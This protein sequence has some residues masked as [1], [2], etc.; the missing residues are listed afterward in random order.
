GRDAEW[1]SKSPNWV[2]INGLDGKDGKDGVI[3]GKGIPGA[4]GETGYPGDNVA[5][6]IDNETGTVY[7]RDPNNNDK[8]IPLSGKNGI[9]GIKGIDGAPGTAGTITTL[10][11]IVKDANGNIYAYVGESDTVAGRDAEWA[12]KSPNWVKINGLNGEDGITGAT[13]EPGTA[14]SITTLDAIIKSPNGDIYVYTGTD[15]TVAGRDAEWVA[16]SPNWVKINGNDGVS[17]LAGGPGAPGAP[18]VTIPADATTWIDTETGIVYVKD[19]DGKWV[20]VNGKD[21]VDGA[22]GFAGGPGVPGDP[23]VTIPASTT[24]WI[25]TTT[26]N[27]YVLDPITKEWV[28]VSGANGKDGKSFTYADFTADELAGLKGADGVTSFV[29]TVT[30]GNTIATFTDAAG[31]PAAIKETIT[32]LKD[33]VTETTDVRGQVFEK[34]TLTYTDEAGVESP[35]DMSTLVKGVETL[36]SLEY[37]GSL[38]ELNY[39]DEAGV[40]T[41]FNMVD[42][43][44]ANQ[45]LT[46]L[47]INSDEGTLDYTDE[48]KALH[49]LNLADLVKEPW[50]GVDSKKGATLNTDNIYTQGWVGIG[51]TAPSDAPNEKLRVNGA[52]TTVNSYYA[53]YVFEDYF[54]GFSD[55]K[56][57][58]K[59]KT[60]A[61]ID[62]YIKKNN[63]LPGITPINELMKTKEGYSFNVSEL[64]I[65]LLE[66]TEELYLHIIEQDKELEAKN[67]E[68]EK[69]KV[70]SKS[71]KAA[72]DEMNA[73]LEKL[74]K[75]MSNK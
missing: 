51:F 71:L 65:Q 15:K 37:D 49:P 39:K 29:P 47:V 25:D 73:R 64:S 20:K 22:A 28:K 54:K 9:D 69:L 2:K 11:A 75:L 7:V 55:I 13:G 16:K 23:G 19:A 21:G 30:E 27:V 43:V 42:M 6:Y 50:Y 38:G 18:G 24:T 74:E 68:I 10:D 33:V 14:G 45:T 26:G 34:H 8:W 66:K 56:A 44:G 52:I 48:N 70:E 61:E 41:S 35:I 36:T 63:H 46:K 4:K 53:D 3:G 1:A 17:G 60:L 62:A 72:T 32:S 57:D 5:I 58:Y 59:F 12:S 67:N 31:N 40:T